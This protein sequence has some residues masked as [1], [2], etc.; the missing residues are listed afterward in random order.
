MEHVSCPSYYAYLWTRAVGFI[1]KLGFLLTSSS[2]V[3]IYVAE[4]CRLKVYGWTMRFKVANKV[5][6]VLEVSL[7]DHIGQKIELTEYIALTINKLKWKWP[8]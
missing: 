6:S 8:A 3:T 7:I 1:S 5:W 4:T 2:K